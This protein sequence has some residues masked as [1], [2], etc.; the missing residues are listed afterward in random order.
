MRGSSAEQA[1][2]VHGLIVSEALAVMTA[3]HVARI[4]GD[5]DVFPK[6]VVLGP[7]HVERLAADERAYGAFAGGDRRAGCCR[8]PPVADGP[9][10]IRPSGL[11]CMRITTLSSCGS[12]APAGGFQAAPAAARS[13]SISLCDSCAALPLEAPSDGRAVERVAGGRLP[14]RLALVEQRRDLVRIELR[15]GAAASS[16]GSAAWLRLF[17]ARPSF[18]A[19][20]FFSASAIGSILALGLLLLGLRPA[21]AF[22]RPAAARSR[23]ALTS[24]FSV[25]LAVGSST[26][27]G[28]PT[29]STSGFGAS[30]LGAS[31]TPS[32]ICEN[33]VRT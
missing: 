24:F 32:V 11:S 8:S 10:A 3:E 1:A 31:F 22:G 33:S 19:S 30:S 25:T 16:V 4:E 6:L 12:L 2:L 20:S 9:G 18:F 5:L 21:W 27:F 7:Q 28:S 15:R 23:A 14:R 29:F 17:S 13:A 26:G